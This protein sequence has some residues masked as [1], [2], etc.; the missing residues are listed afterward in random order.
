MDLNEK[1]VFS[2]EAGRLSVPNADG[3]THAAFM[4]FQ[5]IDDL[6]KFYQKSELGVLKEHVMP[7]CHVCSG[8]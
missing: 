2:L 3:F 6:A 5:K 4:R 8:K 1:K 7:Y